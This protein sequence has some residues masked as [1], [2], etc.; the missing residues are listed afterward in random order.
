MAPV[1]R[2]PPESELADSPLRDF[3]ELLFVFYRAARRPTLRQISKA[4]ENADCAGTAS[5]ETVRRMLR[6]TTVPPNWETVNAVLE[7]LCA[8]AN[9]APDGEWSYLGRQGS[10]RSHLLRRWHRAIDESDTVY[11]QHQDFSDEPPF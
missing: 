2:M 7:G 8:L 11:V 3:V 10:P 4:I 5:T 1:L 9:W 6:G